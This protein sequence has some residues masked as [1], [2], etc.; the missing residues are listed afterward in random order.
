MKYDQIGKSLK[1]YGIAGFLA[2]HAKK[3]AMP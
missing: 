2:L 3:P 1:S